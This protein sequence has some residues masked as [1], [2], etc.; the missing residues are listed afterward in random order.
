MSC[1]QVQSPNTGFKG[2][3]DR[4]L[5]TGVI[6]GE[7]REMGDYRG[8]KEAGLGSIGVGVVKRVALE[9]GLRLL[10]SDSGQYGVGLCCGGGSGLK[11]GA[12]TYSFYV[13][14]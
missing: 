13:F 4:G 10:G 3:E 1:F 12:A 8:I 9:T 11:M 6:G 7:G 14:F 2:V 5:C